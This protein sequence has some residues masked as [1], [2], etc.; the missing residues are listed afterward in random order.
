MQPQSRRPP[1]D[2]TDTGTGIGG[3]PKAHH[4]QR[5]AQ[6]GELS[7]AS[8]S[9]A[10]RIWPGWEG[11]SKYICYFSLL[12]ELIFKS[13]WNSKTSY[14]SDLGPCAIKMRSNTLGTWHRIRQSSPTKKARYDDMDDYADWC[15]QEATEELITDEVTRHLTDTIKPVSAS[16]LLAFWKSVQVQKKKKKC[17]WAYWTF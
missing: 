8:V 17:G 15:D 1:N 10:E 4:S 2:G 12:L 6:I 9:K 16:N 11:Q 5:R 14:F 3:A 13:T 7:I